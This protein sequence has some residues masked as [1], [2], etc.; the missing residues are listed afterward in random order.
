MPS[1]A[2][3][4]RNFCLEKYP[5][6]LIKY[7]LSNA[8]QTSIFWI[9]AIICL[10]L[11]TRSDTSCLKYAVAD[12]ALNLYVY[13]PNFDENCGGCTVLH[14]LVDRV[15]VWF[16]PES[17]RA[18]LVPYGYPNATTIKTNQ[19]Y[20]TPIV[21][22]SKNFNDGFVIYPESISGN[23]LKARYTVR[24]VLYFPGLIGGG[25][26]PN[27]YSTKDIVACY[28]IGVCRDIDRKIRKHLL[29]LVDYGL[30][31]LDGLQKVVQRNG[32]L[33][34]HKKQIWRTGTLAK[35]PELDGDLMD[36]TLSKHDRME[37]FAKYER[38]I[39]TDPATFLSVEAAMSGCLSVVMPFENVTKQ[40]WMLTSYGPDDLKYGIA[41]GIEE[42]PHAEQTLSL[43][44]SNLMKQEKKQKAALLKFL[45]RLPN[46]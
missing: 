14:Y 29:K 42:I 45:R 16:E 3:F 30:E 19:A 9:I 25:P 8:T 20:K 34:H 26:Q 15:N 44:V 7:R 46:Y 35:T 13:S 24:W 41:Y 36:N 6:K 18:Y 21:P 27:E 12:K 22:Q 4:P 10:V 23:P 40:E 1:K 28:S 33:I 39:T 38:F 17:F 37:L 32:T 2:Q 31:N 5:K 11:L 43:V